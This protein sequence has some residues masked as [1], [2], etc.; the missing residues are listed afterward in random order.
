[1]ILFSI[2]HKKL[3]RTAS[4]FISVVEEIVFRLFHPQ[5]I[6]IIICIESLWD[7]TR[8]NTILS[9][10]TFAPSFVIFSEYSE[11]YLQKQAVKP[12]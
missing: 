6:S 4:F 8:I 12:A 3:A 7:C 11:K 1:M 5:N 2:S 10:P 9:L